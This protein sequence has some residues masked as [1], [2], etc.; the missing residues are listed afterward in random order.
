MKGVREVVRGALRF[1]SG[2]FGWVFD[3]ALRTVDERVAGFAVGAV[4]PLVERVS[5]RLVLGLTAVGG[6]ALEPGRGA[7]LVARLAV[8]A[9]TCAGLPGAEPW[10]DRS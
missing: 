6:V 9:G 5:G 7:G 8:G 4:D 2:A 3:A 1:G 10:V